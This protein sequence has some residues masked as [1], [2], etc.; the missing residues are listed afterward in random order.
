MSEEKARKAIDN[1]IEAFNAQDLTAMLDC[2]N[3][4]FSWIIN[5][6][7]RPVQ[8]ASEFPSMT[9]A[10]NKEGWHHTVLDL[11]EE[12]EVWDT[13]AHFKIA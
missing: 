13:K 8:E 4:P 1:Y 10:L 12:G 3:F 5:A 7:V 11:A 9:E 6:T 2:L